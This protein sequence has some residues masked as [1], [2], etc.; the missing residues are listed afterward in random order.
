MG[1]SVLLQHDNAGTYV[2]SK[3][4][5]EIRKLGFECLAHP[6]YSPNLAPTTTGCLLE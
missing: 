6:P 4:V 3:K 5:A 2:S 1:L